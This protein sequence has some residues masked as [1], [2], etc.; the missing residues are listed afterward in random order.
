MYFKSDK[1]FENC[2]KCAKEW[3]IS[4]SGEL[5]TKTLHLILEQA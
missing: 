5:D 3:L 1:V 4:L 2:P